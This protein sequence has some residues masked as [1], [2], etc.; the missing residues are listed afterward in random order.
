MRASCYALWHGGEAIK[1]LSTR[2]EPAKAPI[3]NEWLDL[4]YTIWRGGWIGSQSKSLKDHTRRLARWLGVSH[5]VGSDKSD[6]FI[7]ESGRIISKCLMSYVNHDDYLQ[8]DRRNEVEDFNRRIE[9]SLDD[10]NFISD[11][12]VNFD[13][14]HLRNMDDDLNSGVRRENDETMPNPG[15]RGHEYDLE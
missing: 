3:A 10:T 11:G 7:T 9:V 12:E 14:L 5:R 1:L 2:K 6:R 4:N 13:N 8:T 15:L